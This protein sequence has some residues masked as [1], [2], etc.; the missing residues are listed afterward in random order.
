M[1]GKFRENQMWARINDDV[2]GRDGAFDLGK[3]KSGRENSRIATWNLTEGGPRYF[4]TLLFNVASALSDRHMEYLDLI[5]NRHVGKP[6]EI[7]TRGRKLCMDYLNAVLELEH[8]AP[9]LCDCASVIEIGSGYGRSCHSI[10]SAFDTIQNY[11]IIDLNP[12]LELSRQYLREVLD[13]EQFAKITFVSNTALE[14]DG[15]LFCGDLAININSMAEMDAEVAQNYLALIDAKC[16][17]FYCKNPVGKYTPDMVGIN[18]PNSEAVTLALKS[19]LLT[20][21]VDIFNDEAIAAQAPAF[22]NAYRPSA[23][24]QVR[25]E[26]CALP[27]SYY[28]Q[29]LY[30]KHKHEA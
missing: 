26:A 25:S 29:A 28:H 30:S 13:S 7:S 17:H 4:K 14:A 9:V 21:V 22:L 23:H 2:I 10:L 27:W 5:R 18:A 8:M 20:T 19:G 24:W 3:F 16:E 6:I 1:A 12:C 15:D 11:T